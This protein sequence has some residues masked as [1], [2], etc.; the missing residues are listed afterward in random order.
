MNGSSS[1]PSNTPAPFDG[2]RFPV[3]TTGQ[4]RGCVPDAGRGA[5]AAVDCR[6]RPSAGLRAFGMVWGGGLYSQAWW[7]EERWRGG[8]RGDS[9]PEV[10]NS[11]RTRFRLDADANDANA[12]LAVQ[13]C[14]R[15]AGRARLNGDRAIAG[16]L[17]AGIGAV[18]PGHGDRAG[19]SRGSPDAIR[20]ARS[21]PLALRVD[22]DGRTQRTEVSE[23]LTA[24]LVVPRSA[25]RNCLN[26]MHSRHGHG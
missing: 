18:R 24:R 3:M 23:F 7:R 20:F 10:I 1:S 17:T 15:H 5:R 13:R 8:E 16:G 11:F 26:R 12:L 4:R 25:L 9:L 19:P 14:G 22:G 21:R 2:P 6:A